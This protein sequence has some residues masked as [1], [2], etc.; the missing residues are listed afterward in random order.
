MIVGILAVLK[1][2]GAYVPLDP[3]YPKDRLAYILEDATPTIA[4][5]DTVGRTTLSE[6]S[7]HFQGQKGKMKYMRCHEQSP[8]RNIKTNCIRLCD[9]CRCRFYHHDRSE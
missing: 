2:G 3:S 8:N 6:A 9:P 5:V 7:Q 1:A 4:L